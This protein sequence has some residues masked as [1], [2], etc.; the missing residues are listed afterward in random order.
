MRMSCAISG[1]RLFGLTGRKLTGQNA[2][3]AYGDDDEMD[4]NYPILRL[5]TSSGETYYCRTTNWSSVGVATG[6]KPETVNFTL[7]PGVT[8]GT[9][10]AIVSAAGIS[11]AP[12]TITITQGEVEDR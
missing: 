4:E 7:N 3:A 10:S 11:S 8:A 6:T 2:G 12:V 5:V 9:Y 1:L